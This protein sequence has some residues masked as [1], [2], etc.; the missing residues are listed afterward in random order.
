MDLGSLSL[1][2]VSPSLL[3]RAGR[4]EEL[5]PGALRTADALFRSPVAPWLTQGF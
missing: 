1:G 3:A 5:R 2:G 4:V